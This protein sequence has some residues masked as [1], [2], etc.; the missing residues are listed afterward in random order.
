M[1][2]DHLDFLVFPADETLY[3]DILARLSTMPDPTSTASDVCLYDWIHQVKTL[4]LDSS[5]RLQQANTNKMSRISRKNLKKK[6]CLISLSTCSNS[7]YWDMESCSSTSAGIL[8]SSITL[9]WFLSWNRI[10]Q[11]L[12]SKLNSCGIPVKCECVMLKGRNCKLAI[13]Y[14]PSI[15]SISFFSWMAIGSVKLLRS[16]R[17]IHINDI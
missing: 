9:K 17:S 12:P 11:W 13:N 15:S 8:K 4:F 1:I 6:L 16:I 5:S 2:Q 10:R 14:L 7:L 3:A